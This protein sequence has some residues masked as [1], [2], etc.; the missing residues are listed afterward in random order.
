MTM[1]VAVDTGGTKTLVA[2]FDTKGQIIA[3]RKFPTPKDVH[4][5]AKQTRAVVDELLGDEDITCLSVALPGTVVDGVMTWAGNLG[6]HD[7]DMKKLMEGHYDCPVIVENDANLAGLAETRV[8][9][10]VPALSMYY[11]VSTGIGT[12]LIVNGQIHPVFSR[13][14]GGRILLKHDNSY[15]IWEKFASGKAIHR[16]YHKLASEITDR[17]TW[18]DI[19]DNIAQGML[20]VLP[21][22]RP[23]IVIIGGGVGT[24]FDRFADRVN[25]IL[26]QHM[27]DG[28]L[29]TIVPAV[30]AEE[31][32]I[33][34]C[35]YHALDSFAD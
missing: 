32:V 18:H 8:L 10:R 26:K 28:Y 1:I 30:H 19:A 12:G 4:D 34:G 6:W 15:K 22:L 3:E 11:T 31:A 2:V 24:Y 7:V 29:P 27:H 9:A 35:Y 20:A 5:Y 25:E 21:M 13:A 17:H 14:E 23:D 33:Y 16:K